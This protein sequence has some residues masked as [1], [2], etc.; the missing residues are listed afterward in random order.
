MESANGAR[1]RRGTRQ[2]SVSRRVQLK[3]TRGVGSAP[4]LAGVAGL[5]IG[6]NAM[7]EE[8]IFCS[9][10]AV[11]VVVFQTERFG[12][13]GWCGVPVEEPDEAFLEPAQEDSPPQT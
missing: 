11:A 13:V 12:P 10:G 1:F 8:T 7:D 2:Q 4:N 6:E 5:Q 3:T 9:C